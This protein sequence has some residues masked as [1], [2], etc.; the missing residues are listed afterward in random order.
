MADIGPLGV[1]KTGFDKVERF[2][3]TNTAEC[4]Y[5]VVEPSQAL[6][7]GVQDWKFKHSNFQVIMKTK[8]LVPLFRDL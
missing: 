8:I 2:C 4:A 1:L 7:R 6:R 5:R 3:K